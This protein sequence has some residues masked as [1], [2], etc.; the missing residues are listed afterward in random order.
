MKIGILGGGQLARMLVQAGLPLGFSFLIVDPKADAC[1]RSLGE[2]VCADYDAP[3]AL[4]AL[5]SCDRVTCDFENVP[6]AALET[7]AA[8]V[9]VAPAASAVAAAQDRLAEKR[10]FVELGIDTPDFQAV[11]GR[12]DL[13]RAADAL[14]YPLVLKTRRMG[15][16]GKGQYVIQGP[17][18]L[19]L[20]WRELGDQPLIAEQFIAFDHECAIT[21]VRARDGE[22]RFW[23]LSR[24]WHRG[25]ILRL[26]MGGAAHPLERRAREMVEQL[27]VALDYVGCLTLELFVA[28]D[29]LLANEFAPRVHN[30]AHWTIEGAVCSQFE[31]HLRAVAGLPLGATALRA[32]AV[33]VNFIG[34]L[35]DPRDWLGLPDL[36][37]HDYAKQPRAGRK[38]GHA[39]LLAQSPAGF[40]VLE[41]LLEAK[42]RQTL[43]VIAALPPGSNSTT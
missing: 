36:H 29:R 42:D 27:A 16:D 37:W 15:Y 1:A 26:A 3:R 23:P 24:T 7:L 25:G 11:D 13:A 41:S 21:A 35:P 34:A 10:R 28:G 14:G 9:A 19:E 31:N 38:V 43:A 39:T 33:M 30:S 18:D 32:P 12:T 40:S 17:E 20:A 2:F 8:E 6:A 22:L 4:Q 5:A